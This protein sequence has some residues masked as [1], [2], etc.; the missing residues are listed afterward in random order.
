MHIVCLDMEGVLLPE[1]WIHAAKRFKLDALKRTTRDEPDYDKLMRFRLALLK[2][3]G[4]KLRDLQKIIAELKPLPGAESF[5]KKLHARGPV[6]VLSDTY[7]EF[8][9]PLMRKLDN[10][11][12]LCNWLKTDRKGFISGYV[13]RQKDG[14]RKA[15]KAFQSAGFK[16]HAAGDSYN[17]L[18]MIES[19]DKGALF[20]PPA[21][22]LKS[23]PH[24][25]VARNYDALLKLL[26]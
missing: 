16:V 19:A 7:Y 17:D 26:S 6:V 24:L 13:L 1:I 12:L 14:K 25:P 23:H 11:T 21:S 20:N 15:V 8:A 22:I 10:A 18:T 5:L 3:E 4:I 9:L 2:R